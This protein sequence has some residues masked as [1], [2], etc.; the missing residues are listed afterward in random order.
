MRNI[1]VLFLQL[2]IHL[3]NLHFAHNPSPP[4]PPPQKV[5]Y[6]KIILCLSGNQWRIIKRRVG[7]TEANFKGVAHKYGTSIK[8][9]C[10]YA[11]IITTTVVC[12]TD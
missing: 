11:A 12:S 6:L 4:P 8:H 7:P 9:T 10:M 2:K 5:Q 1:N 3:P